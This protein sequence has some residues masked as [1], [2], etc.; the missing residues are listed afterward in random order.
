[1]KYSKHTTAALLEIEQ[2]WKG[3]DDT[4]RTV[5][6]DAIENALKSKADEIAATDAGQ[7]AELKKILGIA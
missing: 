6:G 7:L 5:I 1:M 4:D 3:L 2:V